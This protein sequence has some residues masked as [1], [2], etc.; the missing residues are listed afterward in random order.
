M[1]LADLSHKDLSMSL[2]GG[3][4]KKLKL[5]FVENGM[6]V[7]S[8][9]DGLKPRSRVAG[10]HLMSGATKQ[11]NNQLS[12]ATNQQIVDRMHNALWIQ[13]RHNSR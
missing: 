11:H 8:T 5:K 7:V 13:L 6:A 4:K 1:D 12:E 9:V 10:R 3:K 2:C